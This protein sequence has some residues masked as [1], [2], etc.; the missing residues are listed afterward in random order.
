MGSGYL[1]VFS[2][3]LHLPDA[4][5]LKDK[6]REVQRMKAGLAKHF[7]CSVAEVDHH[8]RWQL[9]R[10]SGC[11]VTRHAGDAEHL[12]DEALRWLDADPV[13]QVV[14][15]HREIVAVGEDM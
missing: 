4:A 1:G 12:V 14:S 15:R 7:A 6:R 9:A 2:V 13:A 10:L 11:V 5:S 8:D 3:D